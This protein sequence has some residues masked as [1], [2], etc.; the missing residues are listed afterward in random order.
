MTELY[1]LFSFK[2]NCNYTI[3]KLC[4]LTVT[5]TVYVEPVQQCM[6]HRKN[7]Y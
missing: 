6:K 3:N 2:K 7:Y 4:E 1:F 5:V